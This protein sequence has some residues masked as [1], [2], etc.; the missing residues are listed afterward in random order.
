[1]KLA[2]VGAAGV[3]VLALGLGGA[4]AQ[5]SDSRVASHGDWSVFVGEDPTVCW[6]VTAALDAAGPGNGGPAG[7]RDTHLYVAYNYGSAAGEVSFSGGYRF[8]SGSSVELDVGGRKFT[9]LTEDDWA[10]AISPA[11]DAVIVEA[12]AGAV[13]AVVS[14]RTAGTVTRTAFSLQGVSEALADA[15]ARCVPEYIS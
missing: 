12:F 13:S 10:W 4:C 11:E 7:G 9:L 5:M 3:V 2:V 6:G 14:V 1:M 15:A 8:A